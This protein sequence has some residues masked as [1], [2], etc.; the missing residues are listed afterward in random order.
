MSYTYHQSVLRTKHI[1]SCKNAWVKRKNWA[2]LLWDLWR[3]M[4]DAVF[5]SKFIYT[6]SDAPETR[7]VA[8]VV[9]VESLIRVWVFVTL[10]TVT[11]LAPL[12][13]G[14]PRQEYCSGLPCPPPGDLP[15]PGTESASPVL[16]VC[17]LLLSQQVEKLC[18]AKKKKKDAVI[19]HQ[20]HRTDRASHCITLIPPR[21]LAASGH[22]GWR[23]ESSSQP[24]STP[25]TS[26]MW[27]TR[28]DYEF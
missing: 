27:R 10:W 11:C 14:F 12:S 19:P 9:V 3:L 20:E 2:C 13:I 8:Y 17:S 7:E 15:N 6:Q 23:W 22:L 16:Q 4:Q 28:K 25:R 24:L 21:P 5:Y 18:Q 26:R 1:V